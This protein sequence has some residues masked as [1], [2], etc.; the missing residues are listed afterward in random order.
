MNLIVTGGAG[1]IGSN[2]IDYWLSHHPE[3]TITNV[4]KFTYASNSWFN[5]KAKKSRNY[6]QKQL[7]IFN[8]EELEE[9]VKDS[10]SIVNFAAESHVDKSIVDSSE[11]IKSNIIGVYNLLELIRK[12]DIRF[13]HVSTDEV[14]GSLELNQGLSFTEDSPYNPRNPYS[15]TK[16]SADFIIRSYVNT[17]GIN[18]TISNCGNNFGPH[19]H[20]EKLIPKTIMSAIRNI[21]IPVYG[22]GQ[23]I[24]DW[25]YVEDHCSAIDAILSRGRSGETYLIGAKNE[26]KNIEVIR[27]ILKILNRGEELIDY[28]NDRPGHDV[29]YSLSPKKIQEELG[30][31]PMHL[32]DEA[33]LNT[34]EHYRNNYEVYLDMILSH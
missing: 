33:L 14:Y 4:D 7:D 19:Q 10:D 23:Q 30:W 8:R 20:P 21:K 24:R 25:V 32:F 31:T 5:R 27:K 16:A 17:Y 2:F 26:I 13:H 18:A 11:F 12:K 29:R 28:V 1:F 3:D 15:A 9:I 22:N 6:K 34:V